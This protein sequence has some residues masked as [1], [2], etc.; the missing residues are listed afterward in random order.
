MVQETEHGQTLVLTSL[1]PRNG[2]SACQ[3]PAERLLLARLL[4]QS[5]RGFAPRPPRPLSGP[6]CGFARARSLPST[7]AMDAQRSLWSGAL[8]C[9]TGVALGA[10]AAHALKPALSAEQMEVFQTGV[11][12]Q[13]L[14]GLA[15]LGC[16][17]L[18][19]CGRR[20]ALAASAFLAG[21][22]L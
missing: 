6:A 3:L 20:T 15:L 13:L 1:L 10:L 5:V 4:V 21:T 18:G 2:S 8:L 11:R 12:Y 22:L 7:G 9:G 17:A 16:S 14:H 19:S